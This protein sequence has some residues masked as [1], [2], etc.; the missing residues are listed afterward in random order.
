M[1]ITVAD[2]MLFNN[3]EVSKVLIY[4]DDI[5]VGVIKVIGNP[6]QLNETG[7]QKI[8]R[9]VISRHSTNHTILGAVCHFY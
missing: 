9:S 5:A 3:G 7:I 4:I 1:K 2:P 8:L 6:V